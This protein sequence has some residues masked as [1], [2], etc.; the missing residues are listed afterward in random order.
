[1]LQQPELATDARFA[2]N[3]RRVAARREL[4]AI[5]EAAFARLT[6]AQVI[7]RLDAAQIANAHMNDM[8]DVWEHAQLKARKRWVEIDTPAGR[9]PALLPPGLPNAFAPRMDAVP[10]LGEHT[11]AILAGL[12]YG[13]DD[14]ARLRA[15]N[16][17]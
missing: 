7:E 1:V 6:S 15:H 14:I 17:I 9:V 3:S 8:H 13:S 5:I 16:A 2:S 11:E 4:R 12:G 10:A